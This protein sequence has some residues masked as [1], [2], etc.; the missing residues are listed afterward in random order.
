ME[1][2]RKDGLTASETPDEEGYGHAWE[3]ADLS[4]SHRPDDS[5]TPAAGQ[6]CTEA[7]TAWGPWLHTFDR[8]KSGNRNVQEACM[9]LWHYDKILPL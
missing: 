9:V 7:H 3:S 6:S 5:W 8:I 2:A 1:K 4:A